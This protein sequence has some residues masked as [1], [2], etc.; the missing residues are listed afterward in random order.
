MYIPVVEDHALSWRSPGYV[1]TL[2]GLRP[3]FGAARTSDVALA[4]TRVV[5]HTNPR[6]A[7]IDAFVLAAAT[8]RAARAN[9]LAPELLAAMLL[10]ESA[11]DPRALSYAGAV[12]IAQFMPSTAQAV[13]VDPFDPYSAIAGSAA[14]LASYVRAY[15]GLY[16][17]PYT[18]ALAAYNAGPGAVGFYHGVPPYPQTRTYI[19]DIADRWAKIAGYEKPIE[20]P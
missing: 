1:D 18:A 15:D 6:I 10:Q 12:G 5:L 20:A 3:F 19:D 7:P 8:V 11:Y 17:N 13:G 16:A 9:G 2:Q 4:I 14:L